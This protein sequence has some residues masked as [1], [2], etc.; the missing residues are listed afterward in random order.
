MDAK[1]SFQTL[2]FVR[3]AVTGIGNNINIKGIISG[4]LNDCE[5]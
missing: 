2:I 5:V 3:C 1:V 4:E